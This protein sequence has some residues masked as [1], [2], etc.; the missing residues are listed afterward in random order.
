MCLTII[1][2]EP[3]Q[4]PSNEKQCQGGQEQHKS[5]TRSTISANVSSYNSQEV[6]ND[7][8]NI[9][10]TDIHHQEYTQH[11][12]TSNVKSALCLLPNT[13]NNDSVNN[14]N[15]VDKC[16]VENNERECVQGIG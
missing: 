16:H 8:A 12:N 4:E 1:I 6:C 13:S 5:R 11:N 9:T 15:N 2:N 3:P 7:D 14:N 10:E